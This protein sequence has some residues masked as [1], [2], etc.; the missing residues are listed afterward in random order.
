MMFTGLTTPWLLTIGAG[1]V[2]A[3]VV[4]QMLLQRPPQRRVVTILFWPSALSSPPATVL[5]DRFQRWGSFLLLLLIVLLLSLALSGPRWTQKSA[6][7]VIVVDAGAG[8]SAG[9]V[10]LSDVCRDRISQLAASVAQNQPLAVMVAD[11]EP[12]VILAFDQERITLKRT[13][14]DVRSA[15]SPANM[16]RA[17]RQAYQM[18]SADPQGKILLVTSRTVP[19]QDAGEDVVARLTMYPADESAPG[20][21]ITSIVFVPE[22]SSR[23]RGRVMVRVD[24][25]KSPSVSVHLRHDADDMALVASSKVAGGTEFISPVLPANG[26]QLSVVMVDSE[27]KQIGRAVTWQAPKYDAVQVQIDSDVPQVVR[28]AVLATGAVEARSAGAVRICTDDHIPA[29]APAIVVAQKGNARV[30]PGAKLTLARSDLALTQGVNFETAHCGSGPEVP[31][32]ITLFQSDGAAVI[33]LANDTATPKL[34]LSSAMFSSESNVPRRIAFPMLIARTLQQFAGNQRGTMTVSSDRYFQDP[35]L[36]DSA[37]GDAVTILPTATDTANASAAD[38][39][40]MPEPAGIQVPQPLIWLLGAALAL[41][42]IEA[43]LHIKR[44]IA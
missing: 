29:D 41:M 10:A 27:A 44:R 33:S 38:P 24:P 9:N 13:L 26:A 43:I 6:P 12:R 14:T 31:A 30:M 22:E 18:V 36:F 35:A 8:D 25:A 16:L 21:R 40:A 2:A 32:G 19:P 23:S 1:A 39:H 3:L 17:L 7:V 34:Y 28:A 37:R 42:V 5:W 11:P 15:D 4:L 20:A